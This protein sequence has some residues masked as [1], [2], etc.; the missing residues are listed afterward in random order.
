MSSKIH[1]HLEVDINDHTWGYCGLLVRDT[2]FQWKNVT[3]KRCLGH[4]RKN[5]RKVKR[6]RRQDAS[7]AWSFRSRLFVVKLDKLIVIMLHRL[8]SQGK[9]DQ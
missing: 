4:W 7:M 2:C 6:L 5:E 1:K 3:C 8:S 9:L